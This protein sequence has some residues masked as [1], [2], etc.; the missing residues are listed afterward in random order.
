METLKVILVI[1]MQ[2]LL[3]LIGMNWGLDLAKHFL[4]E[5]K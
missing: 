5:K 1:L 2:I 3:V 4:K